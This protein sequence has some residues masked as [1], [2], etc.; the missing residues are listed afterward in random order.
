MLVV[1]LLAT[2]VLSN[3]HL[4]DAKRH[5]VTGNLQDALQS[6][7][8]AILEDPND[9]MLYFR[10]ATAWLSMGKNGNAIKDFTKVLEL[11][12]NSPQA[13]LQRGKLHLLE[14]NLDDSIVDLKQYTQLYQQE[15]AQ[16]SLQNA[17]DA[18]SAW[19]EAKTKLDKKQFAEAIP[20]LSTVL[21]H[22]PMFLKARIERGESHLQMGETEQAVG[23]FSRAVKLKPDQMLNL[24]LA[25]LHLKL[26]ELSDAGSK[27]KE[28]LRQDPDQKE[29]KKW[30]RT[31]KKMEKLQN[32]MQKATETRKWRTV[33]STLF[34]DGLMNLY[35]E[36]GA[37][38]FKQT[39]Y[40]AACLA[41]SKIRK[42]VESIEW[43]T[44]ALQM[45]ENNIEALIGRAESYLSQGDYQE[46]VQDYERAFKIN[47]NDERVFAGYQKAQK[48]LKQAGMRDYYKILDV[49]RSATTKEIKKAYRKLAQQ[50][51]PDKYKGDLTNEQVQ[52][53]MAEINTAYE[54]LGND[55]LRERYD[56]GDDP[57]VIYLS[58][59]STVSATAESI[60][61]FPT[62]WISVWRIVWPAAIPL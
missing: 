56:S 21:Q 52:K 9:H 62:W 11:K 51:H 15:D 46:S 14:G 7:E 13:L 16:Q 53:K 36:Q 18:Q 40:N 61:R 43:C 17:L 20:Y 57:N 37:P 25:Q 2:F 1:P 6:F 60:P 19:K 33:I 39:G 5:L 12:Q 48:L 47:R 45:D 38:S 31:I 42:D 24:K 54:V 44:K 4:E 27:I 35:L 10:R 23:D 28:C 29:C 32:T 34:A 26:G 49:P 8:K 30:F 58:V 59:G 3:T 55:E 41:Y 22:A 50:W